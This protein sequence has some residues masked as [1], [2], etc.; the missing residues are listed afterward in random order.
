MTTLDQK[1]LFEDLNKCE[2]IAQMIRLIDER[3][4]LEKSP[5][6]T[7]RSIFIQGL[8]QGLMMLQPEVK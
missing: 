7:V 6:P 2:N 5:G 8:V 1:K 4:N 3:Y